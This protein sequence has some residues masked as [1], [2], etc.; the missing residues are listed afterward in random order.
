[1]KDEKKPANKFAGFFL[2]L[3]GKR[4]QRDCHFIS[5]GRFAGREFVEN[6][7]GLE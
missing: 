1:M 7:S 3:S 2:G 6:Y 4:T 5:R